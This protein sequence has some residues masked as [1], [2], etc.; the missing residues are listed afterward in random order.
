MLRGGPSITVATGVTRMMLG[1]PLAA[2]AVEDT[3]IR[4]RRVIA[5]RSMVIG[6]ATNTARTA[7]TPPWYH[8]AVDPLQDARWEARSSRDT[9]RRAARRFL[10]TAAVAV[11][12]VI[13]ADLTD[14]V[15]APFWPIVAGFLQSFGIRLALICAAIGVLLA[16]DSRVQFLQTPR[17]V[18][19]SVIIALAI[20]VITAVVTIWLRAQIER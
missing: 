11:L 7:V 14:E 16:L 10:L 1:G 12:V 6:P 3:A 8:R 15:G 5:P 18:R 13:F 2:K 20:A 4:R 17:R 19:S 9:S